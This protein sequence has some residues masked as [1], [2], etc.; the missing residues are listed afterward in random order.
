MKMENSLLWENINYSSTIP[1]INSNYII[2]YDLSKANISSLLY[3]KLI[4][5]NLYN[6]LYNMDKRRR[7]VYIGNAQKNNKEFYKAIKK[8]ISYAK[9]L[10]FETNNIQDT[11]VLSIRNDAIFIIGSR[12]M[13]TDFAP[14]KFNKNNTYTFYMKTSTKLELFYRYD[15]LEDVEYFDVKGINDSVLSKNSVFISFICDTFYNIQNK[16]IDES[17]SLFQIFYNDFLSRK[18]DIEYYRVF[19]HNSCFYI[20]DLNSFCLDMVNES[21][22]PI[23]NISNNVQILRDIHSVLSDIYFSLKNKKR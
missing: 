15:R 12:E 5:E 14:F 20:G 16:T 11:E 6:E 17:I 13:Q 4:D 9:R 21:Y 10:F 3:Y 2:E 22:K 7:E 23:L 1:Y 8:G 18:L 19:D